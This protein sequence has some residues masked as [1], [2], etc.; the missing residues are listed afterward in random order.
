MSPIVAPPDKDYTL[1]DTTSKPQ[2]ILSHQV[3]SAS[4]TPTL[5]LQL[6]SPS[7]RQPPATVSPANETF[8]GDS[9]MF[10]QIKRFK[11]DTEVMN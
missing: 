10:T 3:A 7:S 1:V 5:P 11:P 6:A 2:D 4:K 8:D 9:P